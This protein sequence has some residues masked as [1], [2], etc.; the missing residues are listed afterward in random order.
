MKDGKKIFCPGFSLEQTLECGQCFRWKK[1]DEGR[2][3]VLSGSRKITLEQ[4]GDSILFLGESTAEERM[5]WREYFDWDRNYE[6]I[7]EILTK[8]DEVLQKAVSCG[9]GIHI[10]KQDF[11]ETLICFIIS[12][13][14]HIPRIKGIIERIAQRYGTPLSDGMYAFP[15]PEA[16]AKAG[17]EDFRHLGTGFRARYLVDAV[18]KVASGEISGETLERMETHEA[19]KRLMGICGVGEKVADCVLLFGLGRWDV[20]PA[21]VWIRRVME[22]YYFHGEKTP[23]AQIQEKA[24]AQFGP[25][26]GLAQQYLF[27]YGREKQG[28]QK[29]K[30]AGI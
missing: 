17:E 12:Q 11:F 15:S 24:E 5:F 13:N 21:D 26:R 1:L 2:Y 8:E 10:L 3:T 9:C 20:F 16:L 29:K 28:V 14:N 30:E 6:N 27:Y 22:E 23:L 25:Y 19:K 18:H 7:K 4:A